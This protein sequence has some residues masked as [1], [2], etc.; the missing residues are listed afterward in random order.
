MLKA[1]ASHER[2]DGFNMVG[3]NYVVCLLLPSLK[4]YL[5]P[6]PGD[7]YVRFNDDLSYVLEKS[8]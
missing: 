1:A 6:R 3:D 4:Q 5:G 2:V 8:N 7:K